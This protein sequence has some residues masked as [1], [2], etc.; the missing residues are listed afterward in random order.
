M[1]M[2]RCAAVCAKV[3][4]A[5]VY[6]Q[7]LMDYHLASQNSVCRGGRCASW[8]RNSWGHLVHGRCVAPLDHLEEGGVGGVGSRRG[9]V[10]LY[11]NLAR[12]RHLLTCARGRPRLDTA[13]LR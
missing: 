12:H 5:S 13:T 11:F 4:P 9:Y 7:R 1:W 6:Y 3:V 10:H 8:P 2:S